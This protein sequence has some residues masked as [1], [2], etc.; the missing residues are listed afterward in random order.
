MTKALAKRKPSAVDVGDTR[1]GE[2][3]AL[4]ELGD[5]F[6]MHPFMGPFRRLEGGGAMAIVDCD[7][8]TPRYQDPPMRECGWCYVMMLPHSEALHDHAVTLTRKM[9][10]RR[11]RRSRAPARTR[12]KSD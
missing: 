1:Q 5:G 4:A 9:V 2:S 3:Y 10:L 12:S 8:D 7:D 11:E 6:V